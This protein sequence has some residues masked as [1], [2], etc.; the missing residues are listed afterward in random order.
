MHRHRLGV[1]TH[2]TCQTT[3][4]IKQLLP[5]NRCPH[6][7]DAPTAGMRGASV[8]TLLKTLDSVVQKIFY[9]QYLENCILSLVDNTIT[10]EAFVICIDLS[11]QKTF[12]N[13]STQL[14][15]LV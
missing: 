12:N 1:T 8:R 5:P 9:S 2:H 6:P 10:K 11:I 3:A 15:W 7:T 13:I 4:P 14:I